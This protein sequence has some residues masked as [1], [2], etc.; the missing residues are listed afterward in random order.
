MNEIG[1]SRN[2]AQ[3]VSMIFFGHRRRA[4]W[5][6]LFWNDPRTIRYGATENLYGYEEI[7]AFRAVRPSVGL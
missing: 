3:S 6:V 4:G 2:I 5:Q 1:G 7:E